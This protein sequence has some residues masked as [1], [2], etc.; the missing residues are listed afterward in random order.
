MVAFKLVSCTTMAHGRASKD[1]SFGDPPRNKR[2]PKVPDRGAHMQVPCLRPM[3]QRSQLRRARERSEE[4]RLR[5][6][7]IRAALRHDFRWRK[8]FGD[9]EKDWLIFGGIKRW[10]VCHLKSS[11]CRIETLNG[12]HQIA[13]GTHLVLRAQEKPEVGLKRCR[14]N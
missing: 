2:Q 11:P 7:C 9:E 14:L 1:P 3:R 8:S 12:R 10:N 6:G 13:F 4:W 5:L